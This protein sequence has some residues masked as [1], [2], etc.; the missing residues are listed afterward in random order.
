MKEGKFY[1]LWVADGNTKVWG[2]SR[3]LH[4]SATGK[5]AWPGWMMAQSSV[6]LQWKEGPSVIAAPSHPKPAWN[7]L[8]P[9]LWHGLRAAHSSVWGYTGCCCPAL[10]LGLAPWPQQCWERYLQPHFTRHPLS[11]SWFSPSSMAVTWE[12]VRYESASAAC[13][14]GESRKAGAVTP[15]TPSVP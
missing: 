6:Q 7:L 1:G 2:S 8:Q 3:L 4:D 15:T 12:L 10:L 9:Q 14:W 13:F 5:E 11:A